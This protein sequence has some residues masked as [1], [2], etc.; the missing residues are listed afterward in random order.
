MSNTS[1]FEIISYDLLSSFDLTCDISVFKKTDNINNVKEFF[2]I[3][4][5]NVTH[6]FYQVNK[7]HYNIISIDRENYIK[8][9]EYYY[10]EKDYCYTDNIFK[11][12]SYRFNTNEI[13]KILSNIHFLNKNHWF[14]HITKIGALHY[15][16]NSLK[17]D[18]IT[19]SSRLDSIT[20]LTFFEKQNFIRTYIDSLMNCSNKLNTSSTEIK[21]API[22]ITIKF[23]TNIF[24]IIIRN[25]FVF[26]L[27]TE[28]FEKVKKFMDEI[29][30]NVIKKENVP[31]F[32]KIF[33]Q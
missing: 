31:Y 13:D 32:L 3:L 24:K 6:P 20:N 9:L 7:Y 16:D 33:F 29:Y 23:I 15:S 2:D 1:I 27:E 18:E 10:A 14:Y 17:N 19:L 21:D 26:N 25:I 5:K 11:K 4:Y 12:I 28:L 22:N 8:F 30:Q